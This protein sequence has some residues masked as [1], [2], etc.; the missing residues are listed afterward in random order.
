MARR[1]RLLGFVLLQIA[2]RLQLESNS[3]K[4]QLSDITQERN[5]LIA[6]QGRKRRRAAPQDPT[7]LDPKYQTAGKRCTLFYMLWV[8]P[9][10]FELENDDSYSEEQRY[11]ENQPEMQTQGER[12][13]M[14]AS[15]S[16]ELV[17]SFNVEQHFRK[18]VSVRSSFSGMIAQYPIAWSTPS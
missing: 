7:P 17:Q 8:T 9:D 15:M 1:L 2:K 6:S 14:L 16:E 4:R 3:Q 11:L 12:Q 13:D 10:L 18:V 5:D